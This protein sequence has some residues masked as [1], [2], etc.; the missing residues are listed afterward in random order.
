MKV[1]TL[2]LGTGQEIAGSN[3]IALE[4]CISRV[5]LFSILLSPGWSWD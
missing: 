2:D 1:I 5:L 4:N 3:G